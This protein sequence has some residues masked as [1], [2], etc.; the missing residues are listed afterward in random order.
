MRDDYQVRGARKT[1]TRRAQQRD[2]CKHCPWY[3]K[4]VKEAAAYRGAQMG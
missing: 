1:H 2:D 4:Y 3:T